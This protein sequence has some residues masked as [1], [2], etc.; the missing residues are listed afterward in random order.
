MSLYKRSKVDSEHSDLWYGNSSA[1]GIQLHVS[2]PP[3]ASTALAHESLISWG[4]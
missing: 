4:P 2:R 3:P 1:G